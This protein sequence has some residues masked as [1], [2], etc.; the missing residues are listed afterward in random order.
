MAVCGVDELLPVAMIDLQACSSQTS[1][2]GV[3]DG[4]SCFKERHSPLTEM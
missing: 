3:T 1:A 2:D 4:I